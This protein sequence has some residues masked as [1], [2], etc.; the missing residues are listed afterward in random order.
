MSQVGEGTQVIPGFADSDVATLG[1]G[2]AIEDDVTFSLSD[3]FGLSA[4]IDTD[5]YVLESGLLSSPNSSI[6]DDDYMVGDSTTGLSGQSN[7]DIFGIDEF[8]TDEAT[9]VISDIMAASDYAAAD[10]G[11]EPKVHDSEIQVS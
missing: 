6:I 3:S 7:L 1:M 10:H 9:H 4:A 11:F 8:F 5:R 2:S